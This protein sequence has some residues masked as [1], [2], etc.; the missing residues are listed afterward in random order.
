MNKKK[1][2]LKFDLNIEQNLIDAVTQYN[3]Y[4]TKQMNILFFE[5][6]IRHLLNLSRIMRFNRQDALLI[7]LLGSGRNTLCKLVAFMRDLKVFE[8]D[9]TKVYK[10]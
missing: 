9:T 10:E 5:V 3:M 1:D 4:N 8:I 2:Y 7:G 6:I